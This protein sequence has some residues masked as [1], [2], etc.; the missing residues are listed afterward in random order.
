MYI[1]K[2]VI[3]YFFSKTVLCIHF[4]PKTISNLNATG[5]PENKKV[6]FLKIL[7]WS[8]LKNMTSDNVIVRFC[9][10]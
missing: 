6:N 1:L 9:I 3:I 4:G 7:T 5:R 10:Y 8:I 2:Y